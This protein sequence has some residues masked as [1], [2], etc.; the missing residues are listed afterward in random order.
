MMQLGPWGPQGCGRAAPGAR[1]YGLGPGDLGW[2]HLRRRIT[3]VKQLEGS[4][5]DTPPQPSI[6]WTLTWPGRQGPEFLWRKEV[7]GNVGLIGDRRRPWGWELSQGWGC[8]VWWWEGFGKVP[9]PRKLEPERGEPDPVR[10]GAH[11]GW[12]YEGRLATARV[13]P[14]APPEEMLAFMEVATWER[15]FLLVVA[16]GSGHD[17]ARRL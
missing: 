16:G 12:S 15:A 14:T 9:G 6:L 11:A 5:G 10:A 8:W 13:G 2:C 17:T 7:A 4:L 3:L 1:G